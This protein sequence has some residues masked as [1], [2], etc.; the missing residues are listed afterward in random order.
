MYRKK[1]LNSIDGPSRRPDYKKYTKKLDIFSLL[2]LQ[3]KLR[4]KNETHVIN[5]FINFVSTRSATDSDPFILSLPK[6]RES[7]VTQT[8]RSKDEGDPSD[9]SDSESDL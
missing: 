6:N 3:N 2:I 5:I 9:T 1:S 4:L 7:V 8:I